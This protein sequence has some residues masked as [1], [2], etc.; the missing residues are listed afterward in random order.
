MKQGDR[1]LAAVVASG[2]C[3]KYKHGQKVVCMLKDK[4][5]CGMSWAEVVMTNGVK[6]TLLVR[7][8]S[9]TDLPMQNCRSRKGRKNGCTLKL[10][11]ERYR[12]RL[13]AVA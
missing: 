2:L 13:L 9:A 7:P 6:R 1:V 10:F 11:I 5:E 12:D 8:L 3:D 4:F